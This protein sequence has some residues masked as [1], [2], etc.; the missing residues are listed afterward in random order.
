MRHRPGKQQLEQATPSEDGTP[1]A[2]LAA[3]SSFL[4][5][6]NSAGIPP[7]PAA[8]AIMMRTVIIARL[9]KQR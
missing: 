1:P 3:T 7:I 4:S 5:L 2:A 8:T 9:G 6:E